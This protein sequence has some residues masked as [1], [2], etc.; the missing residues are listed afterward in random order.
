MLP[1]SLVHVKTPSKMKKGDVHHSIAGEKKQR[2]KD[3]RFDVI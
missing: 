3:V 2:E 1:S